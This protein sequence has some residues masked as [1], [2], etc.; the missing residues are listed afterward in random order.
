[1]NEEQML[2]RLTRVESELE[3]IRSQCV[4]CWNVS[5]PGIEARLRAVETKLA[6]YVGGLAALQIVIGVVLAVLKK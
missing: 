1:M 5:M 4:R 2:E 3:N 6:T